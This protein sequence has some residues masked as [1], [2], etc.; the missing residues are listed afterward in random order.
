MIQYLMLLLNSSQYYI[1]VEKFQSDENSIGALP[2][3][4]TFIVFHNKCLI[5]S[6][7]TEL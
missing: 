5:S 7:P 1:Y 4:T 3:S 6:V 2:N